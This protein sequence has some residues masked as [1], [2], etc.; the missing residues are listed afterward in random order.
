[1]SFK[2]IL[3][4]PG[5]FAV[6]FTLFM[7]SFGFAVIFPLLPFYSLSLGAKPFELGMLTATFAFFSLVFGPV[8]GKLADKYGRR[9]ILLISTAG[10]T[11]PYL[12]FAFSTSLWQL[13]VARAFEG[14][15]AAGIFPSCIALLSDYTDEKQRGRAMGL[16]SMSFSLGFIIGPAFGGIVSA[17]ASVQATFILAAVATS[18]NFASVFLQVREPRDKSDSK[19]VAQKEVALLSH[20]SSPLLFLFLS[21]F[22][23][24]L[25]IGG[26]DATL[27]LYTSE[28][29]GFTSAEVGL[30]FTYVGF[31]IM[32]MQFV[33]GGLVNKYGEMKLIAVGF[34][35][36]GLGF[37]L[38]VFTRDWLTLLIPL[39]VFVAGNA[40]VFPSVT[41]LITKR[42]TGK[43]AAVLGLVSSFQSLGQ[44]LG[45]LIAGFLYGVH[46]SYAFMGMGVIIFAYFL[47]FVFVGRKQ[48]M[49]KIGS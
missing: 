23:V 32:A 25:M 45:P 38:L 17:A 31:L 49:K 24:A 28:R 4:I 47:A 7:T 37:L 20:L 29:M 36:S 13:F 27:A 11:I 48:L 6:L 14:I 42:V 5:V 8:M 35:L 12:V 15:F 21:T 3:K 2:E 22:V 19:D 44:V 41:S 18:V 1:M 43:K 40:M 46:H 33:A 39:A 34:L 10:F 26:L 30:V 16:M 9:K